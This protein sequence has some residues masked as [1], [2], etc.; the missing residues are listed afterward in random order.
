[1]FIF[2]AMFGIMF[3]IIKGFFSLIFAIVGIPKKRRRYYYN[4]WW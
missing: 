4:Y 2:N 1:M 3:L